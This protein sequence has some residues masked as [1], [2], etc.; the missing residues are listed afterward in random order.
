MSHSIPTHYAN[1]FSHQAA[2]LAEGVPSGCLETLKSPAEQAA[3]CGWT[4]SCPLKFL[5]LPIPH[6]DFYSF[7]DTHILL[8]MLCWSPLCDA[9]NL[10]SICYQS[11]S[12]LFKMWVNCDAELWLF[13]SIEKK[14]KS[15]MAPMWCIWNFFHCMIFWENKCRFYFDSVFIDYGFCIFQIS[16]RLSQARE[17]PESAHLHKHSRAPYNCGYRTAAFFGW[18]L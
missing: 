6:P 12:L 14:L 8:S 3:V 13:V 5:S 17:A 16:C 10:L 9:R 11:G 4:S 15:H 18:S 7:G 2:L 1:Y